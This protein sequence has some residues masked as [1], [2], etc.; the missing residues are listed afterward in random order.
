MR[1]RRFLFLKVSTRSLP[2]EQHIYVQKVARHII[3]KLR[4]VNDEFAKR[5]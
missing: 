2:R 1:R 5:G 3:N 4:L